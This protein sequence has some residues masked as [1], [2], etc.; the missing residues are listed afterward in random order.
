M[1]S[2]T[3]VELTRAAAPGDKGSQS[4][5]WGELPEPPVRGAESPESPASPAPPASPVSPDPP[6]SPSEPLSSDEERAGRRGVLSGMFRFMSTREATDAAPEGVYLDDLDRGQ[7]DPDLY[8]PKHHAEK[9]RSGKST[10]QYCIHL[11]TIVI[12]TK[13]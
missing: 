4:W 7:V 11:I 6:A 9:Y 1:Q 10:S 2:D 5:R 3:E 12:E 8:F 13:N